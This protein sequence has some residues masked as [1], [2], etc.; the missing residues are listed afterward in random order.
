MLEIQEAINAERINSGSSAKY[1]KTQA[2]L[3]V[4]KF[5]TS[6]LG[7]HW[8]SQAPFTS[9]RQFEILRH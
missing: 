3:P 8:N 4:G 1:L 2:F 5:L 6:G 7:V 9:G